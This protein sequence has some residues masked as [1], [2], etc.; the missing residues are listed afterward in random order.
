MVI[1]EIVIRNKKL[2]GAHSIGF[3]LVYLVYKVCIVFALD[4]DTK[5]TAI[6]ARRTVPDWLELFKFA[7]AVPS[8]FCVPVTTSLVE[9]S[10]TCA[11]RKIFSSSVNQSF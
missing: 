2:F 4:S 11:R 10:E 8:V 6:N 3:L 9:E 7:P 1:N 5:I